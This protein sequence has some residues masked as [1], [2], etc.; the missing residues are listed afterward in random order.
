[1]NRLVLALGALILPSCSQEP[2]IVSTSAPAPVSYSDLS[3]AD[4]DSPLKIA[5]VERRVDAGVGIILASYRGQRLSWDGVVLQQNGQRLVVGVRTLQLVL[6]VGEEFGQG[7]PGTEVNVRGVV[8]Q[9]DPRSRAVH[10]MREATA[11]PLR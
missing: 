10:L 2:E 11:A 8:A 9:I 1:M 7:E 5:G 3:D 6:V 4:A